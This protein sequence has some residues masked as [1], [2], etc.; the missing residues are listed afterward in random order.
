MAVELTR[1]GLMTV[2]K[3]SQ[4]V[5]AVFRQPLVAR[6]RRAR[7]RKK[8]TPKPIPQPLPIEE[9]TPEPE[10]RRAHV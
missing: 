8:P 5:G 7:R 3:P 1:G 4:Q 2:G 10:I 6:K 9:P